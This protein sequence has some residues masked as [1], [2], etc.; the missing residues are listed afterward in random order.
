M[1]AAA[2]QVASH[3]YEVYSCAEPGCPWK[4]S[5]PCQ[6]FCHGKLALLTVPMPAMLAIGRHARWHDRVEVREGL[7]KLVWSN[8]SGDFEEIPTGGVS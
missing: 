3:G 7:V 4:C 5:W 1:S 2:D 6:G 8:D